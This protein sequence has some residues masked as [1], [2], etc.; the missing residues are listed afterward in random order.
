MAISRPRRAWRGWETKE[1]LYLRVWNWEPPRC[2][3]VGR[4]IDAGSYS[5]GWTLRGIPDGISLALPSRNRAGRETHMRE[6]RY[7]FSL[8]S[9]AAETLVLLAIV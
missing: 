3:Q 7:S 9:L 6:F 1:G 2:G 4:N 8:F 5:A